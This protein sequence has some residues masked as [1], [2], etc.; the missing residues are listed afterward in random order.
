[1]HLMRGYENDFLSAK[2]YWIF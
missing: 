2:C 1:M